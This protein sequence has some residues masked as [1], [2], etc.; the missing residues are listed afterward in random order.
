MPHA[1]PR[2]RRDRNG[3]STRG[4]HEI[5]GLQLKLRDTGARRDEV[6]AAGQGGTRGAECVDD[7]DQHRAGSQSRHSPV[8]VRNQ[9]AAAAP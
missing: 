1:R 2:G 8:I 7:Q 9:H 3:V 5:A 6:V 4:E